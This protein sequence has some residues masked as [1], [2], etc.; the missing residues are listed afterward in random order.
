MRTVNILPPAESWLVNLNFPRASRIQGSLGTGKP[1]KNDTSSQQ[2]RI[3]FLSSCSRVSRISTM[4]D[5][6]FARLRR[7]PGFNLLA[8]PAFLPSVI[9]SFFAQNKRGG[10]SSPRSVTVDNFRSCPTAGGVPLFRPFA[11]LC[12]QRLISEKNEW[13]N[14]C[15]VCNFG[16]AI[17]WKHGE[18]KHE[19]KIQARCATVWRIFEKGKEHTLLHLVLQTHEQTNQKCLPKFVQTD[20]G[21]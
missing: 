12:F 18:Q 9:S 4:A 15:H 21:S 2:P 5:P 10:G 8:L 17:C 1:I 14:I 20:N 13:E 16:I 3:M 6:D 11:K 7:G 19:R